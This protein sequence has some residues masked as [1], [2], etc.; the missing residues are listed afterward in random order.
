[1]NPYE[2]FYVKRGEAK[3]EGPYDLVK[4][5]D[6]LVEKSVT[7]ET[8]V[9]VE[10]RLNWQPFREYPQYVVVRETSVDAASRLDSLDEKAEANAPL[11]PIPSRAWLTRLVAKA[12]LLLFLGVVAYL[13]AWYNQ[14]A[15]TVILISGFVVAAISQCLIFGQV[16][17]EDFLTISK[18]IFIPL[19]DDYYYGNN[20]DSYFFKFFAKYVG[21]TAA[22]A[23]AAGMGELHVHFHY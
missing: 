6:L 2:L 14:T 11:I 1:M 10:G 9:R 4:M 3:V 18:V 5:G 12:F 19:Y 23:A 22:I 16:L 21:L 13:I 17:N 8:L 15:G 7:P 20:L